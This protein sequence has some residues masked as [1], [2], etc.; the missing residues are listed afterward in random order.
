M[1]GPLIPASARSLVAS[2]VCGAEE[3]RGEL[4]G[5]Q[6]ADPIEDPVSDHG[7]NGVHGKLF[8]PAG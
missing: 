7:E 4:F 2:A 5:G 1:N 6:L 3:N 8:R